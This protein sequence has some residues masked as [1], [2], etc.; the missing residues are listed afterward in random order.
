MDTLYENE[1]LGNEHIEGFF[2]LGNEYPD[3][4]SAIYCVCR[5]KK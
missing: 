4:A 2:K 5:V 1:I 3:L